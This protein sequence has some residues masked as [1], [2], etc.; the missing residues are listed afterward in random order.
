MLL[1]QSLDF[2]ALTTAIISLFNIFLVTI[3]TLFINEALTGGVLLTIWN[4]FFGNN[5]ILRMIFILT[6]IGGVYISVRSWANPVS[7]SPKQAK[8]RSNKA[9]RI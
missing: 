7:S 8:I 4:L 5:K 2:E 3:P 6:L 9:K 1:M